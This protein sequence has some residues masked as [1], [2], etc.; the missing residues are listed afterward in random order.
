M[1][2]SDYVT[3]TGL[4]LWFIGLLDGYSFRSGISLPFVSVG[5]FVFAMGVGLKIRGL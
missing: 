2:K 5:I 4:I 1:Q 3:G